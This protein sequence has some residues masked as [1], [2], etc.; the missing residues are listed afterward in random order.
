[1]KLT[2]PDTALPGTYRAVVTTTIS[3]GP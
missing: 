1:V 2:I 3:T